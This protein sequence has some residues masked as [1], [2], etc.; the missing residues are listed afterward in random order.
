M[1]PVHAP[2]LTT[3]WWCTV[4]RDWRI[5]CQLLQWHLILTITC[6][7]G[8]WFPTSYLAMGPRPAWRATKESSSPFVTFTKRRSTTTPIATTVVFPCSTTNS[9]NASWIT[10]QAILLPCWILV[11]TKM[12]CARILRSIC[13][14][15]MTRRTTPSWN[16]CRPW[17]N[18]L[19]PCF[20]RT[21]TMSRLV[22]WNLP[23]I[24]RLS[25]CNDRGIWRVI[26]SWPRL[27]CGYF[28][29]WFVTKRSIPNFCN[30]HQ[31][32]CTIR[33]WW[34]IVEIFTKWKEW[35]KL[36]TWRRF[37]HIFWAIILLEEA[38][39][40]RNHFWKS[41]TNDICCKEV[42]NVWITSA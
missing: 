20:H 3:S 34:T 4:S 36:W 35:K 13:F 12:D 2:A 38:R 9:T 32:L 28:V 7:A 8:G 5:P 15:R 30:S 27:I 40:L 19:L 14:P 22:N 18:W 37:E 25:F 17:C 23:F 11:S 42:A 33:Y 24:V 26:L 21:A 31:N 16:G 10:T 41:H 39:Q 6:N 1:F 29:L